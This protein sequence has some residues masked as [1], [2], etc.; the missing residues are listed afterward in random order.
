VHEFLP[1]GQFPVSMKVKLG[2]TLKVALMMSAVERFT[3]DMHD[4]HLK[5]LWHEIEF[6]YVM[7]SYRSI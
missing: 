5:G 3:V 6:Q 7:D 1:K 2:I 4:S